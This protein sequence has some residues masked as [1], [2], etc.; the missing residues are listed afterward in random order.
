M[1]AQ[2]T[3][4]DLFKRDP[5]VDGILE[6][7]LFDDGSAAAARAERWR[8][9]MAAALADVDLRDCRCGM[10]EGMTLDELRA[11]APGCTA[12]RPPSMAPGWTCPT[13]LKV[14][15]AVGAM[16]TL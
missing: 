15:I 1:T 3:A 7:V 2:V 9:R 16:R 13:W 6:G 5:V 8:K 14:M 10:H 12:P 11:L 4:A